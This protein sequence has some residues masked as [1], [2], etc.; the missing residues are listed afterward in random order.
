MSLQPDYVKSLIENSIPTKFVQVLSDDGVHFQA[1]VISSVFDG[2]NLIKRQQLVYK[3]LGDL[4]S[5][6]KLHALSLQTYTNLE[7]QSKKQGDREL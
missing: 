1:T 2:L 4:I 3:S 6:G 7:W 5:S